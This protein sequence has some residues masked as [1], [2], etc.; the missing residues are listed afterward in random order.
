MMY[1]VPEMIVLHL[2]LPNQRKRTYELTNDNARCS[3]HV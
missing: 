1:I 2:C 3:T